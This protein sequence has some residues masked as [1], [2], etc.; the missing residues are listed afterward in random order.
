MRFCVTGWFVILSSATI[1]CSVL[2]FRKISNDFHNSIAFPSSSSPEVSC[3]WKSCFGGFVCSL[4]PPT[5]SRIFK[6]KI[7]LA[8]RK[9]LPCIRLSYSYS[10][11]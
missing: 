6:L 4:N 7:L 2:T 1:Q 10:G 9:M 3:G 8:Q 5:R 11:L